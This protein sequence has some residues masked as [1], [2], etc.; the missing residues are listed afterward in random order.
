MSC[1]SVVRLSITWLVTDGRNPATIC[2]LMYMLILHHC[3]YCF[4]FGLG[5]P[6]NYQCSVWLLARNSGQGLFCFW[7]FLSSR[8]FSFKVSLEKKKKFPLKLKPVVACFFSIL[9]EH[10]LRSTTTLY[11]C[12]FFNKALQE[13]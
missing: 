9:N 1:S 13:N 3:L 5:T 8:S 6:A 11:C 4:I 12:L 2:W 7:R 10:N